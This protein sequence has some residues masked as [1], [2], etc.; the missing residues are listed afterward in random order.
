MPVLHGTV[1]GANGDVLGAGIEI[2]D[3][4]AIAAVL[5]AEAQAGGTVQADGAAPSGPGESGRWI[6]PGLIDVHCHGGGGGSF[7]DSE[8]PEAIEAAIRVHRAKGTTAML[9]STVSMVDPLPAIEALVPFCESG[10]LLGIHMEGPYVSPHK[11]GAQN[12]KAVRP[13]DLDELESWLEA[14]QGWIKSMTIA[15]EVP[16]AMEAAR[17]LWKHGAIPSWGHTV[18]TGAQA[19]AVLEQCAAEGI[20]QS[21]THLF[22]AMPGIGHREPGPVRELI[23]S[24]RRGECV[25]ELVADGVHVNLDLV[26][27][28]VDFVESAGKDEPN[29]AVAFV[30]DAIAGAGMPDGDYVLGSLPVTIEGGVAK[31]TGSDTIAGGS[32]R[33]G[34]E[35]ERTVGSG[36]LCLEQAVRACVQGPARALGLSGE[37]PGVNLDFAAGRKLNCVVLASDCSVEEVWR[38]GERIA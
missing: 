8:S 13:P 22:N 24:A 16:Q 23:A 29:A 18:A 2:D 36:A 3:D 12:P 5:P 27:D 33:L 14:G 7:P 30:T 31:L 21:A 10:D 20:G 34:E 37:E 28:V 9:A 19:R 17:L 4:G 1:L 38:E 6:V 35:I 26:G 15:P 32:A 11:C 25:V